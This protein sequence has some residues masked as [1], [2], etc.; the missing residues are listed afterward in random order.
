MITQNY[1]SRDV[2]A[3]V[4]TSGITTRIMPVA[5]PSK[6]VTFLYTEGAEFR[7]SK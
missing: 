5:C 1:Q 7:Y 6:L 3:A 4:Q 2:T